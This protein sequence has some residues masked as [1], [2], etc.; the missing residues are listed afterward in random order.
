MSDWS[1]TVVQM[2]DEFTGAWFDWD[3]LG[4]G[5]AV[6][7]RP[8]ETLI[9]FTGKKAKWRWWVQNKAIKESMQ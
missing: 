4:S 5:V 9:E 2:R 6:E 1:G 8:G 7:Y 3:V